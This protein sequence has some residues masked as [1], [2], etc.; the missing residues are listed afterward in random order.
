[1]TQYKRIGIDT[2]KAVSRYMHRSAGTAALRSAQ[3]TSFFKRL[4]AAVIALEACGDLHYWAHELTT[5]GHTVRLIPP[6]SVGRPGMHFV[7][8]KSVTQRA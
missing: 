1:M 5:L 6:Q 2:S 4:P 3:M 7:P 8:V